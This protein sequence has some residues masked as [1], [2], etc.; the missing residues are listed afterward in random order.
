MDTQA[1]YVFRC[2]L[3][4]QYHAYQGEIET[5]VARVLASG[6]YTL[7]D[8]VRGFEEAFARYVDMPH[9]I[10]VANATDGL[11]LALKAIGIGPGDEVITTP[12]T[13]IPTC[14]AIVASGATPVFADV[15]PET[16]LLDSDHAAARVTERTKAVMP[17]HIFGNVVDVAAL[18]DRLP[19]R[20]RIV[21]DAAQ[22]HGSTIRGR[23]AGSLAELSVFSFYPTKNLGGYGDG[24]LV[25]ARTP[26][27]DRMLRLLR[28]YGMASKDH[29]VLHGVNSRL[30]ELQAAILRAKLPHLD[31]MNASRR[32][33]ADRYRHEV[34][35]GLL[36][37]Q[38]IPPDVVS[39]YHV[40]AARVTGGRRDALLSF[41]EA[42]GI[43]ANI[44]YVV[45]LH[46][47][48]ANQGLGYRRGD[49]PCVE[50]LCDDAIA[51]QLYP[52]LPDHLL[53]RVIAALNAFSEL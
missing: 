28:M 30:D 21:E 33:V 13:A 47:Q 27:L 25:C 38:R 46:L 53:S 5:A 14:S 9:G 35:E 51:L 43:Q 6:R 36:A 18:R 52:E 50:Q 34:R 32:R 41:L 29:I 11:T 4:P 2:D 7:A 23:K 12:Y 24:G 15:D 22:A 49:L 3:V 20:V 37:Y 39:N 8:E 17:V 1:D 44:Y 48:L 10:G 42:H 40:F 26:E 19:S 45:P 16:F 31:A